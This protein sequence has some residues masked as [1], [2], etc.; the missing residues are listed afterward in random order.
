MNHNLSDFLNQD[1][2]AGKVMAHARLLQ[3]LSRR[4]AA[5]AP[6]SLQQASRIANFK[7]GILVVHA[8]NGAV[9]AKLRQR[10]QRISREM[11]LNGIECSGIEVKVQPRAPLER[12]NDSTC[13]P[14]TGKTLGILRST[15]ESGEQLHH[16][17]IKQNNYRVLT[18]V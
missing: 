9:A 15:A 3:K 13:K 5:V 2:A 14:L 8:D 10:G 1:Q 6:S 11:S 12:H 4:F 7:A 17:L 18:T 16:R